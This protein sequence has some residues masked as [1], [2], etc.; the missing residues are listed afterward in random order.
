[1]NKYDE[2]C[3]EYFELYNFSLKIA[4]KKILNSINLGRKKFN[5][6]WEKYST[7]DLIYCYIN[8]YKNIFG[9]FDTVHMYK[10]DDIKNIFEDYSNQ[11]ID[12]IQ[13]LE[14]L[15]VDTSLT[16]ELYARRLNLLKLK[17]SDEFFIKYKLDD[18]YLRY[19]AITYYNLDSKYDYIKGILEKINGIELISIGFS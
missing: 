17:L 9:N 2:L 6:N 18:K 16:T 5:K 19:L 8:Y 1:M 12:E 14:N 3:D 15:N 10:E 7:Q 11:L 13:K 4:R